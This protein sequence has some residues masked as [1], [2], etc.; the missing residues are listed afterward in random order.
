MTPSE[1]E[2]KAAEAIYSCG[3]SEDMEQA[4]REARAVIAALD[5]EGMSKRLEE[6]HLEGVVWAITRIV[7]QIEDTEGLTGGDINIKLALEER[8]S[9]LRSQLRAV[10]EEKAAALYDARSWSEAV[11]CKGEGYCVEEGEIG[12]RC[13]T[14]E[15][16]HVQAQLSAAE[17]RLHAL[18][19]ENRAHRGLLER[20]AKRFDSMSKAWDTRLWSDAQQLLAEIR[21]AL[22]APPTEDR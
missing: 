1:M 15:L 13:W 7:H 14:H 22:A 19:G 6:A 18:R 17:S 11:D 3:H 12:E 21:S 2:K 5:V 20:A 8:E 16:K 4:T 9:A 10:E